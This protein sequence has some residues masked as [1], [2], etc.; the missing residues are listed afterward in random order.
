[1]AKGQCG[2]TRVIRLSVRGRLAELRRDTKGSIA[3]IAYTANK[4][5][6]GLFLAP[7]TSYTLTKLNP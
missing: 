7:I 4:R 1:M 2:T 3:R 5:L 6:T